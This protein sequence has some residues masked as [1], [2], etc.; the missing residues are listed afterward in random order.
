MNELI[1]EYVILSTLT[2]VLEHDSQTDI[3]LVK[4]ISLAAIKPI[5]RELGLVQNA[6]RKQGISVKK[7]PGKLKYEVL[8]GRERMVVE[9]TKEELRR[10]CEEKVESYIK[11]R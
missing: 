6:M 3:N 4:S 5:K 1:Q 8:Q 10:L 9:Y 7:C 11:E 2:Q